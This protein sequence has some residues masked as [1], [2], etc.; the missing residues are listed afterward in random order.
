[1]EVVHLLLVLVE[2]ASQP[3]RV[4]HPYLQHSNISPDL[5]HRPP[6]AEVELAQEQVLELELGLEPEQSEQ[7][8][9]VRDLQ[10]ACEQLTSPDHLTDQK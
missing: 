6:W 3:A 8:K 5:P 4:D 7:Q 10:C 1:M 9:Q 2:V